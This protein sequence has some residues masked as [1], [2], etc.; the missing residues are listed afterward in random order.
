MITS[1]STLWSDKLSSLES[2]IKAAQA[3]YD[4]F[5]GQEFELG[6]NDC[7]RMTGFYLKQ[8]GYKFSFLKA[9][10]YS[11]EVGARLAL[12]KLG[13]KSVSEIL[14]SK[15]MKLESAASAQTGDIISTRG[16]G[17]VGDALGIVL[18]RNE[19]LMFLEGV[20]G[21]VVVSEFKDAWRVA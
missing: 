1:S 7:A 8:L 2:K 9:G 3:A 17:D 15:F 14:D 21:K 12:K 11:T 20:C 13:F 6:K 18:H 5:N 16:E 19:V 4:K 10:A